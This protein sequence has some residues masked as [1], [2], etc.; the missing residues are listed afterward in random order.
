[1]GTIFRDK[2]VMVHPKSLN[3]L[4]SSSSVPNHGYLHCIQ[5]SKLPFQDG[6]VGTDEE[7]LLGVD[8]VPQ[9]VLARHRQQGHVEVL[10]LQGTQQ[11]QQAARC[12][13]WN[14]TTNTETGTDG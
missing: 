1:M 7:G 3:I 13:T 12:E 6:R 11:P 9:H 14:A 4:I 5:T 2:S 8:C 10:P